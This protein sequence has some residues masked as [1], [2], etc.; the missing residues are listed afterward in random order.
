MTASSKS[1]VWLVGGYGDVGT[2]TAR[3]LLALSDTKVVLAGRDIGAAERIARS[4]GPRVRGE[5]IDA[6]RPEATER[7]L[8]AL[9][10]VSLTEA[11]PVVV[12]CDLVR[13][14]SGFVD[15]SADQ[16][17]A[18]SLCAGLDEVP[19]PSGAYVLGAGL[20]PGISNVLAADIVQRAPETV[21]I[22]VVLEMGL[23]RHHGAA[24]TAWTL[25]H[26]AG[27]YTTV[28][29]GSPT[30]LEAG[31]LKRSIRFGDDTTKVPAV[32][33]GFVDQTM[34][35]AEHDLATVRSFLTVNPK[36]VARLL[37]LVAGTA[38]GQFVAR[39]AEW[40]TRSMSVLP[41]VGSVGTRLAVEGFDRN[42]NPTRRV[43]MVSEHDQAELTA[44]MIAACTARLLDDNRQGHVRVH[45]LV[46]RVGAEAI[47]G[48]HLP[49]TRWYS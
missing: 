12:A 34:I 18:A 35:A 27:T 36:P 33:F 11:L 14:G 13:A 49:R 1:E 10:V 5:A 38:A 39:R 23:G 32:G 3:R 43:H 25:A 47:V 45:E 42:N 4:L 44:T 8:D 31:E 26:L 37:S 41:T 29:D 17:Y 2:K 21:R 19:D 22:D 30:W 20:V 15:S 6:T 24:G 48:A 9:V 7:L 40:W 28:I 16:H 46:T